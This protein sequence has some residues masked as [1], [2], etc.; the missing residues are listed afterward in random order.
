LETA[1]RFLNENR[2][3]EELGVLAHL[4]VISA[5]NQIA[6]AQQAVVSSNVTLQQDETALRNLI[7]RTGGNDPLLKGV[8]IMPTDRIVVPQ[9]ETTPP[10]KELID[11]ALNNRP[12]LYLDAA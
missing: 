6:I 8:S 10:V 11:R 2:R 7:S 4:D 3:R 1:Q 5:E 12:D 9:S